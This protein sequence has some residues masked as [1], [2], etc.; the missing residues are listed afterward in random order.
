M[1]LYSEVFKTRAKITQAFPTINRKS[2]NWSFYPCTDKVLNFGSG[3]VNA[4]NH[5]EL[6]NYYK[7]VYACDS[8]PLSGAN[9]ANINDVDQK[10]GLII[11]EHVF[12]HIK[13]EDLVNG[14]AQKFYDLLNDNSKMVITIPNIHNFGNF[15]VDYDHKNYAPPTD[16][17]AIFCCCG[18]ELVDYFKWSKS[19]HMINQANMSKIDQYLEAFLESNYGLQMDR[20][21]TLVFAKNGQV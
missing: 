21:I 8:D 20:Y 15:F 14:L 4:A 16:L 1:I 10:F 17:A 19:K 11:A 9:Y 5:I 2:R 6:K 13:V 18:F 12:E 3:D 7:N